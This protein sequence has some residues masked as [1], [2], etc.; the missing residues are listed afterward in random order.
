M[1]GTGLRIGEALALRTEDF[2]PDCHVLHV[3]RSVWHRCEQAP[4]T[5]NAIRLVDVPESLAQVLCHYIKG[6]KGTY[7]RRELDGFWTRAM[8]W[9]CCSKRGDKADTT[10]SAAFVLPYSATGAG[11]PQKTVA[12][13]FAK[14]DRPLRGSTAVRRDLSEGMVR[15]S[16]FGI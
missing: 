6:R 12:G 2:D 8:S 16:W 5:P 10:R 1:A 11:R 7:S 3:R 13:P 14:L 9:M 15:E 4:K